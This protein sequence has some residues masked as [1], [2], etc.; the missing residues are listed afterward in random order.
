MSVFSVLQGLC[1]LLYMGKLWLGRLINRVLPIFLFVW[2][3]IF[4]GYL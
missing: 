3:L 1:K 2:V 4:D